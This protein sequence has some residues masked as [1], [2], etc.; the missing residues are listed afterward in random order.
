MF[1]VEIDKTDISGTKEVDG[2]KLKVID[3]EGNLV[4][5]W[6]SGQDDE[7]T[8]KLKLYFSSYFYWRRS[9]LWL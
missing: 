1:D 6:I 2:A 3:E 7:K 5:R 4:E 9:S 8:H